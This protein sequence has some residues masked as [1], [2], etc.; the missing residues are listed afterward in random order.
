MASA[1]GQVALNTGDAYLGYGDT[2]KAVALYRAALTKGSV[3]TNLV[4]LH[5]GMALAQA[6][7]RAGAEAAF[8]AVTGARAD[9]AG[10]WLVFLSQ[11]PA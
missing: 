1:T 8:R 6:G 4:N 7:D 3:D 11:R 2:A 10:Y 9:V 5:L